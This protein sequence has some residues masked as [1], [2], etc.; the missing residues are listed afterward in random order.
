MPIEIADS[1]RWAVDNIAT[2]GDTDVFPL[3]PENHVFH[4]MPDECVAELLKV[5][6]SLDDALAANPPVN[7]SALAPVGYV[8]FRWATEIDPLWNAYLLGL[9]LRISKEI[10]AKRVS[11]IEKVVFSYY[12]G[13]YPSG[14][15]I[16]R[17]NEWAAFQDANAEK[18][19]GCS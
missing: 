18:A 19:T 4:D 9:V 10:E 5:H 8:G 3:P 14:S 1:F 13:D 12:L 2:W 7:Q 6:S 15:D 17:K 16:F 11:P